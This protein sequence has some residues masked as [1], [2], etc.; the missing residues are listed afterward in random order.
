M[1]ETGGNF[2]AAWLG[3]LNADG[4]PVDHKGQLNWYY[5]TEDGWVSLT[6]QFDDEGNLLHVNGVTPE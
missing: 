3:I 4:D 1:D 5:E 2:T 6:F